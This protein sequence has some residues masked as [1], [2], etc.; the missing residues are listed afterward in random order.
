MICRQA[1]L[2]ENDDLPPWRAAAIKK[3]PPFFNVRALVAGFRLKFVVIAILEK[4][5]L[6]MT[7][8]NNKS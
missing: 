3:K 2:R 8:V 6:P 4:S 1:R 7:M 5:I